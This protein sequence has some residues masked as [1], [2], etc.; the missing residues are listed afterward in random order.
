MI[1]F[2]LGPKWDIED[3]ESKIWL[4]FNGIGIKGRIHK[5][6][7]GEQKFINL[8]FLIDLS[9]HLQ[10]TIAEYNNAKLYF[11]KQ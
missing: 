5:N 2:G 3:I 8:S 1:K 9:M 4:S 10:L 7:F 11:R 6:F